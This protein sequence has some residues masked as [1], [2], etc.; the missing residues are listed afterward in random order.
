[1]A[2][3]QVTHTRTGGK[4]LTGVDLLSS[5]GRCEAENPE[6]GTVTHQSPDADQTV[7]ASYHM[8]FE[9]GTYARCGDWAMHQ[10]LL[11]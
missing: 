5:I 2:Y 8:L 6:H 9:N 3:P 1:M 4:C 11:I 7:G 10:P